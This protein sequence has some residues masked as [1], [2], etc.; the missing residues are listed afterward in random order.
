[1][2]KPLYALQRSALYTAALAAACSDERRRVRE[3]GGENKGPVVL[4]VLRNAGINTPAPWCAAAVQ[5]WT[6]SAAMA[7]GVKNPLDDVERE[8]LVAD[9][10][11]WARKHNRILSLP[12]Q[13]FPGCLVLFRGFSGQPRW[14]HIGLVLTPPKDDGPGAL[15]ETIE[16]NTNEA[17]S[18]EGDGVYR[19][20]RK[21]SPNVLFVAWAG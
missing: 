6:D 11:V 9:Y 14:D 18:R 2:A 4:H 7:C 1:M 20:T 17:G 21:V 15:F 16:G 5:D 3:E 13:S 10:E 8:A 19:R 12:T